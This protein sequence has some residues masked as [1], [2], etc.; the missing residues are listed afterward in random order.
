MPR[1]NR[2]G[3]PGLLPDDFSGP[4]VVYGPAY[5]DRTWRVAGRLAP[6]DMPPADHS[7]TARSVKPC[8]ESGTALLVE[9]AGGDVLRVRGDA[10][11]AG[12]NVT[13]REAR[14][15]GPALQ[16]VESEVRLSGR[17]D[18]LGGMGYGYALALGGRL[19]T[20]LGEGPGADRIHRLLKASGLAYNAIV[21]PRCR[22]DTTDLVLGGPPD[23]PEKL[24][25]GMR[26][27]SMQVTADMLAE[28]GA[29]A[30]LTVV[31][32]LPS[33]VS[34]DL[35]KR[36]G[37]CKVFAPSLRYVCETDFPEA[38]GCADLVVMNEREWRTAR[39]PI[40]ALRPTA[41]A[42]VTR[43]TD[44]AS[45]LWHAG[46]ESRE[47]H[48]PALP[49]QDV[50]DPNRAGEAFAAGLVGA[51]A[52]LGAI[53]PEGRLSLDRPTIAEAAWQATLAAWLELDLTEVAF[54]SRAEV[55]E[56]REER[57]PP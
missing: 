41:L 55:R 44:G 29:D 24:A 11:G 23:R 7:V 32:S 49:R 52:D 30:A 20:P 38:L 37:G 18:A 12:R 5:L 10:N 45:V 22:A 25:V 43:G 16:P 40:E 19:V 51:L 36:A 34:R 48:L 47:L 6:P 56:L 50:A 1:R 8:R 15:F 39:E 27:A 14:L 13:V 53:G 33:A 42:A 26:D 54:P 21:V 28:A 35:L 4:V 3:P 57:P 17:S 9:S 2:D 31:C 46:E